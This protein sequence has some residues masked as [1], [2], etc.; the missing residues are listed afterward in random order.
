MFISF[1]SGMATLLVFG[2]PVDMFN[3]YLS[4]KFPEMFLGFEK[5][6]GFEGFKQGT[7]HYD[8]SLLYAIHF[9]VWLIA[10]IIFFLSLPHSSKDRDV[11]SD[12]P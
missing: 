2:I 9:C 12:P 7:H 1:I 8:L 10:S 5:A 6:V 11:T 4:V 3:Q